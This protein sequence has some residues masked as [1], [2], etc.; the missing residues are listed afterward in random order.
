MN[1]R[2]KVDS[3][4]NGRIGYIHIPDMGVGSGLNEFAKTFFPQTRKEGMIIDDRF[5]GGGNVS[6]MIIERLRRE[7]AIAKI[8]RNQKQ[9]FTT[10]GATMTGPM[11]ALINELSASDGD[12]FPYQFKFY[13]LGPIIGKRS[14]GGVI[15]IRGS[16]PF[17]DGGYLYKPEFANFGSSGEWVLEGVG[18]EPDIE[19]SNHPAEL[20]RGYDAQLQRAIEEVLNLIPEDTKMKIP[21]VPPY[22]VKSKQN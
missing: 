9:V 3:A 10:P 11:V 2:R 20:M 13:D 8:A 5:N 16:L 21:P 15:G 6:P 14:W 22:P 4:T 19:V 1:N 7:I 12:L 18:M 17:I